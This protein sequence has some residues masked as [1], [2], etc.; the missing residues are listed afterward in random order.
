MASDS[1]V[2]AGTVG[3]GVWRSLDEGETFQRHSRGMFMEAQVRALAV[4]P[5]NPETLYA[6]TDAGVYRT[7]DGGEQWERLQ[8]P[9]DP[10]SGWPSG[11][12]VW[13]LLIHPRHPDL[14]FAGTCPSGLYRSRDGGGTW[15]KLN[16]ALTP[17]CPPILFSRVTCLIADPEDD[18]TLWAGVEID[19]V[20]RSRDTGETWQR[21]TV[22]LSSLDIHGLL[23]LPG[24]PRSIL[25]TTNNDLNI[26]RDEGETWEPQQVKK[27][28][29]HT[30]CRG[31][32]A[33]ADDPTLV[34]IGNGNG[35]P[36]TT[37][38]LQISRDSGMTWQQAS[39]PH[40]PNSTI[41]TFT[42]H[43]GNPDLIFCA[44]INGG[45]Y[46]SRD[47][48]VSWQKCHHEFGEVRSLAL[49]VK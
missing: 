41:W 43:P 47:G 49:V 38:S 17:E 26:S 23:V 1:I 31:I 15:E 40:E 12:A 11:V 44:S 25:A 13:S 2:Y 14:L 28:F 10:G 4:H 5:Q 45:L 16:A 21:L 6:G 46:R 22:G 3:Q 32:T 37:G 34:L 20:W 35:P 19:G 29:P 33:K 8:T 27:S 42:T 18:A 36:G 48:A 30:Y 24:S 9:F 7:A 39:L